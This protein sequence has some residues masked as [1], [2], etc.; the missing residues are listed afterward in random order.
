[1]SEQERAEA[2]RKAQLRLQGMAGDTIKRLR[3]LA[4][5]TE[6]KATARKAKALLKKY[7]IK[8]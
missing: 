6:D 5:Q 4:A 1:M 2:L 3:E 7:G 8:E